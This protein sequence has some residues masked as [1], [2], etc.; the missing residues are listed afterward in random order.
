MRISPNQVTG[1]NAGGPCQ[2]PIRTPLAARV[3]SVLPFGGTCAMKGATALWC[4]L[5]VGLLGCSDAT[6]PPEQYSR[7]LST[8]DRFEA[9]N[10]YYRVGVTITR[11]D[12]DALSA[13]IASGRK[14]TL[15]AP[16]A[17]ADNPHRWDVE[18]YGGTNHVLTIPTCYGV[19]G[20]GGVEY[21]DGSGVLE[22][23]WK[24]WETAV[25]R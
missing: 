13:A 12:A 18:L 10:R 8:I 17:W 25:A 9:T 11:P 2:L 7:Q 6:R 24:S 14:N 4:A 15:G 22:A 5:A 1:P 3:R 16:M 23:L 21:R 20:L 19:F